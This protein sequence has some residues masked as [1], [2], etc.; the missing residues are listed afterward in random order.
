MFS[1]GGCEQGPSWGAQPEDSYDALS[2]ILSV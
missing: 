1:D 2:G